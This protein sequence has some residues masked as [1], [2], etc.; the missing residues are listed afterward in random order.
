MTV[1]ADPEQ[2]EV[3]TL[4]NLADLDEQDVLEIGCGDGRLTQRYA[5][6][7]KRVLA[8]DPFEPSIHRARALLPAT[9]QAKVRFQAI[10]FETFARKTGSDRFDRAILAWSL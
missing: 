6:R 3:R 4:L 2:N 5:E 9:L 10:P 7:T 8:L 1:H